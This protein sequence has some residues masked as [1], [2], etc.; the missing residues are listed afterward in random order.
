M[1]RK[2]AVALALFVS[3]QAVAQVRVRKN[4]DDLSD[5]ELKAFAHAIQKL[6]DNPD[7]KANYIFW[8]DIHG[9]R[10]NNL[11]PCEHQS[12]L[13]WPWHRA[14]L[15]AFEDAL[16]ASDPPVTSNVTIPYWDWSQPS[17]GKRY[18]K[19]FENIPELAPVTCT[20]PN[21][22]VTTPNANPP[23]DPDTLRDI[24]A[25]G[26]WPDYG[27]K[28]KADGGGKGQLEDQPHD[29]IHGAYIGGLNGTPRTAARDPLFWAHHAYMDYLWAQWQAAHPGSGNDP[30]CG[31][32][33]INFL[34]G[35]SASD[36]FDISILGYRYQP[37]QT[38]PKASPMLKAAP[39]GL[40]R[41][42]GIALPTSAH[43][44]EIKLSLPK[45]SEI[46]SVQLKF[47]DVTIPTDASYVVNIYLAK[48]GTSSA[49]RHKSPPL[50]FFA[51]WRMDDAEHAGHAGTTET[52]IDITRRLMRRLQ[53]VTGAS[54][55]LLEAEIVRSANGVLEPAAFGKPFGWQRARVV[56]ERTK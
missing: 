43:A 24:Q 3:L 45:P 51:A 39:G 2:L 28:V 10:K 37:R 8:A 9:I 35:K 17:S 1:L 46:R 32:C 18:P 27:G 48:P 4:I 54:N 55:W 38:P 19:A 36:Y 22:R 53:G 25:L 40:T 26:K 7:P 29:Y 49:E 6:K 14:Y 5:P 16:R 15:L 42:L 34:P 50:T 13:L 33:A 11:G 30:V 41:I 20:P 52:T 21:C 23:F 47:E 56:V 31:T 44:T 12:E